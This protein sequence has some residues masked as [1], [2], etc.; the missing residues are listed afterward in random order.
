M[1]AFLFLETFARRSHFC[2]TSS[3]HPVKHKVFNVL[4]EVTD[5][6]IAI[7][8]KISIYI[9]KKVQNMDIYGYNYGYW[10]LYGYLE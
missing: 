6:Y 7:S 5:I 9:Q 10:S 4:Y 1:L 3:P 8:I 2:T